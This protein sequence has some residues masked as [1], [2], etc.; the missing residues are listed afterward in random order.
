MLVLVSILGG[1]VLLV[2]GG[3]LLVRGAVRLANLFHVSPLLIGLVLVGFATSTPELVT[4]L[5]AAFENSP[6]IAVGNVVGSNIANILLILG[7]TASISVIPIDRLAFRRD[8]L[9]LA[10]ATLAM[11]AV[12]LSGEM[13]RL[14]GAGFLL[15]LAGYIGLVY[16]QEK[17]QGRPV[18]VPDVGADPIPAGK[19]FWQVFAFDFL[20]FAGGLGLTLLGAQ[21]LVRGSI[22]FASHLGISDTVIGL[23]VVAVGTSMPELIASVMAA[24]RGQAAMSFGN[25]IGSNIYNILGIVGGTALLHPLM[26]PPE[27]AALDI[28]VMLAAM[29]SLFVF[30]ITGWTIHRWEGI[31]MLGLYASYTGWLVYTAT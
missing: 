6:G 3:E 10:L 31:V 8:G 16:R 5:I 2:A 7:M 15:A 24:I 22:T 25:I 4:S 30:T 20:I 19:P 27:I 23:T 29:A 14:A 9:A 11:L 28:W 26:V 1:L 17:G 18:S 12:V 13:G 21:Y